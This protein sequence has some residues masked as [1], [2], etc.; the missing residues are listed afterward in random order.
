MNFILFRVLTTFLA[1]L[2]MINAIDVFENLCEMNQTSICYKYQTKCGD[3]YDED[4][5]I[6]L[7][8]FCK[9]NKQY[10]TDYCETR[11]I[12]YELHDDR[13]HQHHHQQMI[14]PAPRCLFNL[15]YY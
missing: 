7:T 1:F 9:E 10:L 13:I 11:F 6:F 4:C 5:D 2:S 15:L 3:A 12:T 8:Q 14:R